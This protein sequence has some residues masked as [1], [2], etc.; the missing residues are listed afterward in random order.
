MSTKESTADQIVAALNSVCGR[1]PVGLHEPLFA[2]NEWDLVKHCLDSGFVSSIGE[3]VDK[4][5]EKLK[6]YT[7]ANH[8]IAVVNGTAALHLALKLAGV[9]EGDEV[10]VPALTFVATANAVVYCGAVPHFVDCEEATL[11]VDA[12]AVRDYLIEISERRGNHI[13]NKTTGRRIRSIVAVHVFGHP[14]N[15]DAVVELAEEFRLTLV[16]DASE[17]LGSFYR[18]QHTGTFGA[19]GVL[20]FNGNK[21]ITTGG[22]GAI[23]IN[24]PT[25]A[26]RARHLATTAK[27]NHPWRYDHDA[28]GFNYRMPNLNAALGCAQMEK[29]PE[30]LEKKE[31][32]FVRYEA[33]L[34]DISGVQILSEPRYCK[35]N[36]WLNAL[37]LEDGLSGELERLLKLTNDSGLQT[38][39]AWTPLHLLEPFHNCPRMSIS[40]AASITTRLITIPSSAFL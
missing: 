27:V 28:V 11:G 16:E 9:E 7:G 24:D 15:L 35:S 13:V 36:Y 19:A 17:S 40:R 33:A 4:F 29:L 37:L 20:S 6:T 14:A 5:E 21:I 31:Q 32:L 8:A 26:V 1:R 2:G 38:R 10:L 30:M 22:G 39:P 18:G 25:I 12:N 34:R 23:L 3:F